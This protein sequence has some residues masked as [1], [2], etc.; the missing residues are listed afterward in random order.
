MASRILLPH[1]NPHPP[2]PSQ[3]QLSQRLSGVMVL[4]FLS[5]DS[6]R[7]LKPQP[8]APVAYAELLARSYVS[9]GSVGDALGVGVARPD[10]VLVDLRVVEHGAEAEG[11]RLGEHAAVVVGGG[12]V[13]GMGLGLVSGMR[14]AEK[15][16]GLGHERV[17]KS[18][19]GGG[20]IVDMVQSSVR[21]E[22][23]AREDGCRHIE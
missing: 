9:E 12:P 18:L 16:C 22:V 1:I 21:M 13:A 23:N 6:F 5:L 2:Q 20:G 11:E 15:V 3:L 10:D 7:V 19:D 4:D 8:P 14:V 17:G